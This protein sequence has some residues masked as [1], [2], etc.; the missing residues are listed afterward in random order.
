[1]NVSPSRATLMAMWMHWSNGNSHD[2]TW[3]RMTNATLEASGSTPSGDY[4]LHI[5]P[6]A[7]RATIYKTT[8][9]KY[10]PN[11][12]AILMAIAI[13]VWRYDTRCIA[14]WRT[15]S[16]AFYLKPPDTTIGLAFPSITKIGHAETIFLCFFS[17]VISLKKGVRWGKDA[18]Y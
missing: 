16:M 1:M 11:S 10:I 15:R 6:A 7:T 17:I 9:N 3:C 8:M 5:A 13:A 4:S 12:L 14:W 18:P 2:N